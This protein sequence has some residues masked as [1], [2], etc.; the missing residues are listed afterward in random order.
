M[1]M[2][3]VGFMCMNWL[4]GFVIFKIFYKKRKLY[5]DRFGMVIAMSCSGILSLN[6]SMIFQF[7]FLDHALVGLVLTVLIG[8]AI[9]VAFGSLVKFQSIL[10]G[11]SHGVIG[12]LMGNMLGI[13]VKD[14]SICSLPGAYFTMIGQNMMI[15][16]VFGTLLVLIT[17]LLV[18]Y[19]LRV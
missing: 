5:N 1:T 8:G 15:F 7:L 9:G 12:S 16:T 19:S 10:A 11:F 4:I 13:V 2:Y 14:P 18:Y 3:L 17:I 6:L